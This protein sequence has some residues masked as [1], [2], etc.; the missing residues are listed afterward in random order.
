MARFP[1]GHRL[2]EHAPQRMSAGTRTVLLFGAIALLIVVVALI[3]PRPSLR[4]VQVGML[5]GAPTGNY[6]A[7]VNRIADEAMRRKGRVANLASAGSVENVRRLVEGK[8]HCDVHFA[9]VQDGVDVPVDHGLEVI[10]RLPRPESLVLLGRNADRIATPA[11]LRGLRLGIGPDGS[12]TQQLMQRVLVPLEGLGLVVSSHTIDNQLD[13]LQRGELD[14]GAM[15]IDDEASLLA[16]AVKRRGLQILSLPDAASLARRLPF[17]RVGTIE[18]GQIDYV[19]KL[20]QVD[21]EL[22]QVDTLIVGNGCASHSATQGL[23]TAVGEVFPTFIQHNKHHPRPAGLPVS[24]IATGFFQNEGADMLGTYAPMAV[25][26][27]PLPT[28]IQLFIGFS[29]LFSA[30]RAAHRFRLWRIDASRVKIERDLIPL[31][32]AGRT[33]EEIASAALPEGM[34]AGQARS[35]V[36]AINA[37]LT[38]LL[39]R[40]RKQALSMLVPMGEEM[41]Y[42]YQESLMADL[43]HALKTFR[44]RLPS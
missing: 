26:V 5:S 7:T 24:P 36:D 42:R 16:D 44:S 43:M 27:L 13:L 25:D 9:L 33:F 14:L 4:H 28:W 37:K 8:A 38:G 23:M 3:D 17:A 32:G 34:E 2:G 35:A 30:M 18:A 19:G 21:K 29:M 39:Q 10:G 1:R 12:G 20:P 22:L 6:F 41:M 15:V 31:F 40:C 11:D